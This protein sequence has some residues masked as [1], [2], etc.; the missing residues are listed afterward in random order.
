MCYTTGTTGCPRGRA[1]LAPLARCSDPDRRICTLAIAERDGVDAGGPDVRCERRGGCRTPQR[2]PAR[3]SRRWAASRSPSVVELIERERVTVTAGVPTIWMGVAAARREPRRSRRLLGATGSDR[4]RGDPL[5]RR[6][7]RFRAATTCRSCTRGH[8]ERRRSERLALPP[9]PRGAAMT[10][11][12]T[13]RAGPPRRAGRNPRPERRRVG[14][15]L[16]STTGELEVRGPASDPWFNGVNR[17]RRSLYRRLDGSGRETS[18]SSTSA[19]SSPSRTE[20]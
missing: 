20:S 1:A 12:R 13:A 17:L 19:A 9:R 14:A 10:P 16:R 2:W 11:S 8:Y 5:S 6:S 4:R 3:S 18:W 15:A 7:A